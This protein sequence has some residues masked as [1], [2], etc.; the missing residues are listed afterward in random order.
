MTG[1]VK[2]YRAWL[3]LER[4]T[5][6]LPAPASHPLDFNGICTDVN[7]YMGLLGLVILGTHN[8]ILHRL[9]PVIIEFIVTV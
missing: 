1:G 2:F 8:L 6:R 4:V 3:K 5:Y 7:W 9:D